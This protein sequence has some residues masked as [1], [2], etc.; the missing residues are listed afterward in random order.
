MADSSAYRQLTAAT[1]K[2]RNKVRHWWLSPDNFANIVKDVISLFTI[3]H[4][5][6]DD[7]HC[8]FCIKANDIL[9]P[10]GHF[11]SQ[12]PAKSE[13]ISDETICYVC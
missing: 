3:A 4:F 2:T 1:Q 13:S 8:T 10:T 12:A 11:L 6:K 5:R 7:Y 9:I